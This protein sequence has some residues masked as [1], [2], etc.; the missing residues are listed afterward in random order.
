M[1]AVNV[2]A[3]SE[4]TLTVELTK[5]LKTVSVSLPLTTAQRM[6]IKST[7]GA[8]RVQAIKNVVLFYAALLRKRW[9]MTRIQRDQVLNIAADPIEG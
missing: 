3:I 8:D 7:A 1:I 4:Q 6:A 9:I 5:D 2:V